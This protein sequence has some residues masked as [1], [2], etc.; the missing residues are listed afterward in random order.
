MGIWLDK[1]AKRYEQVTGRYLSDEE[2][3]SMALNF[4]TINL[5]D[6]PQIEDVERLEIDHYPILIR[7]HKALDSARVP[8]RG[9]LAE[10]VSATGYSKPQVSRFLTGHTPMPQHFIV[11]VCRA[12]RLNFEDIMGDN[13]RIKPDEYPLSNAN[14]EKNY[15]ETESLDAP[16]LEMLK[17]MR[18]LSDANRWVLV[19]RVKSIIQELVQEQEQK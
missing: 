1:V 11:S 2:I 14:F 8:E 19:G 16:M 3:E 15:L 12:F 10:I 18:R 4:M 5:T 6:N 17:E 7:F 13:L 9:R